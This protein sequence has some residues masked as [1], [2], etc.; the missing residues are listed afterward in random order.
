MAVRKNGLEGKA[1][2]QSAPTDCAL[3]PCPQARHSTQRPDSNRY[4]VE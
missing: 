2:R 3:H 4:T 1:P